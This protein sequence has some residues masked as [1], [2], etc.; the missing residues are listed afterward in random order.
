MLLRESFS[1]QKSKKQLCC[2]LFLVYQKIASLPRLIQG[3]LHFCSRDRM[4]DEMIVIT[5]HCCGVN[6]MCHLGFHVRM[7]SNSNMVAR[8][9]VKM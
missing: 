1:P 4:L 6:P 3:H 2:N 8:G 7:I 5:V 9:N